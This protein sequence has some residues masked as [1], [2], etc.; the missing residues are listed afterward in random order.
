RERHGQR[1][2]RDPS[3]RLDQPAGELLRRRW[4]QADRRR[5]QSQGCHDAQ[6]KSCTGTLAATLDDTW[7]VAYEI[8]QRVGGD[9]GTPGLDGPAKAPPPLKP[10]RLAVLETSGWAIAS[11]SAKSCLQEALLRLRAA[12]VDIRTRH[13]DEDVA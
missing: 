2:A 1:C 12:G 4:L 6:S 11:D 3:D 8:A 7:Q 5:A 13:D 9:A 10:Q